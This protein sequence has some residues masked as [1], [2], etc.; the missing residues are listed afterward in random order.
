MRDQRYPESNG[1][2]SAGI[3]GGKI[4]PLTIEVMKEIGVD[5]GRRATKATHD[6]L[7]LCFGFVITLRD[8]ARSE[9]PSFPQGERIQWHF[10]NPLVVDHTKQKRMFRSLRNQIAH[11][12]RLFALV[13]S[14]VA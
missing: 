6:V 5:L 1:V 13:Q 4:H 8:R 11:R 7:G 10:D 9:C 2:M 3:D 14:R 12:V